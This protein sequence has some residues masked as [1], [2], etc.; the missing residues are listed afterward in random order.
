MWEFISNLEIG[1]GWWIAWGLVFAI[2]ETIA[3]L[4]KTDGDTLSEYTR[5]WLGV[6]P[7]KQWSIVGATALLG[8]LVWFGWHVV[9]QQVS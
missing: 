2:L 9:F 3:I 6:F 7:K 4:N 8:F 5:K 1:W